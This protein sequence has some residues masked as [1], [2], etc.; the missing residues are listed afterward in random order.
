MVFL[1][2]NTVPAPGLVVFQ[3]VVFKDSQARELGTE[4][5]DQIPGI[6]VSCTPIVQL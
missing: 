6:Q 1:A 2:R 4:T 5:E 3:T